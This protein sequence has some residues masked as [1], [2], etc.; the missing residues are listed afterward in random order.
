MRDSNGKFV[1]GNIPANKGVPMS[2]EVK[3]KISAT[4]TG[5]KLTG[6]NLERAKK[7]VIEI[8][9][10]TRFKK[11]M[12]MPKEWVEKSAKAKTKYTSEELKEH[13]RQWV[14]NNINHVYAKQK[15]WRDANIEKVKDWNKKS[16]IK[17][18]DR[19]NATNSKRRA[20]KFNRTPSWLTEDDLWI[21]KEFYDMAILR[22]K[23][24]NIKHHVD[25]IIP[26][27]GKNVSGLHVP[28]NL[29]VITASENVRKNNIFKGELI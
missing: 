15:E 16:R 24:T 21:I 10:N 27:K 2:D 19:V 8:G 4:K 1:K 3:A 28:N 12:T 17:H 14:Q 6:A 9:K 5:V 20:D 23:A 7:Q 25:H 13:Q 29:Q 11:G 26:L 22:T 18:K